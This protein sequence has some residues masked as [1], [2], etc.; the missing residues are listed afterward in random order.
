M[1]LSLYMVIAV[2]PTATV[3]STQS[4]GEGT[5]LEANALS[6]VAQGVRKAKIEKGPV[7]SEPAAR[8]MEAK[9]KKSRI[10]SDLAVSVCLMI[11]TNENIF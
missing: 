2:M 5:P 4:Q 6:G 11:K 10:V 9:G 1:I 3:Y 7:L 8:R